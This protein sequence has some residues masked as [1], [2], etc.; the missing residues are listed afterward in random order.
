M[1]FI[2][3][4]QKI[5]KATKKAFIEISNK[6]KDEGIYCFSL[7]SDEGAMT[8]CPSTNTID[9]L[10]NLNEE[11]K[12]ELT[13]Y[14]FDPVEWK[15]EMIG[16]DEE[17]DEICKDLRTELH[18]NDFENEY[19]NEE[20]FVIF[21]NRLFEI[22]INVLKRLKTEG[23]FKKYIGQDIFLTFSV[24]DFEYDRKELENIIIELNDNEY[25]NEYLEWMKTWKE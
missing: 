15:Y 2:K 11:E 21:R 9:F 12:E 18:K 13:Y 24:S 17:F 8:V 5:E 22:C 7:Y 14:K 6:Y 25:K 19:E 20:T 10:K 23:F 3:L 4:E 16:G 1:N